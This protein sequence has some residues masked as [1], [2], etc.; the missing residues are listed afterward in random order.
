MMNKPIQL[1][2]LSNEIPV[3]ICNNEFQTSKILISLGFGARDENLHEYGITHFIEHLLCQSV[4]G[5]TSFENL[6]KKIEIL[7]GNINF[8]TN[9]SKIGCSVNVIPEHLIN[10]IKVIAPQITTPIFDNEKIEREKNIILSEYKRSVD[11]NSWSMLKFEN[12]FHGTG[13]GHSVLGTIETIKSFTATQLSNY[14]FSHLTCDKCNIVVAGQIA[15]TNQL[16]ST[17][18][19]AFGRIPHIP[20]EHSILPIQQTV[21]HDLKPDAQN[22]KLA[23]AFVAKISDDPRAQILVSV[24]R[25]ILQDRL[26]SVLRY[27]KGLAYFI[28]CYTMGVMD[29]KLY[30]IGTEFSPQNIEHAVGIIATVCKDLLTTKPITAQEL[31]IARNVIKFNNAQIIDS[32]DKSCD[33]QAQHMLYYNKI[34]DVGATNQILEQIKTSDVMTLGQTLLCAPV[35][36]VT[37]G[38]ALECDVKDVWYKHFVV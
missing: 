1:Y 13:L 24:F 16:L 26:M 19:S 9:Y 27:E 29:T 22:I 7:G 15:D 32:L 35:S 31:Y 4:D 11:N 34:Y 38:P 37:Q 25:K 18:E 3:I 6:K 12:L 28:Q 14:Y 20:Y 2:H 5:D 10:I 30:A 36:V 17:L 21:M 33:L 23:L 8:Y